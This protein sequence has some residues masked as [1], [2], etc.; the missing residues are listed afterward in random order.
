M[1]AG[2][3]RCGGKGRA[4]MSVNYLYIAIAVY[5]VIGFI[6]TR[7]IL[8]GTSIK[9][10]FRDLVVGPVVMPVLFLT[11]MVF[12]LSEEVWAKILI[13]LAFDPPEKMRAKPLPPGVDKIEL[14]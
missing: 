10:S 2:G 7:V 9:F 13:L 3:V 4:R 12:D 1:R 14:N 5:L 11:M 8:K 6:L